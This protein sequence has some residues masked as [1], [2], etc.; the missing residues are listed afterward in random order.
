MKETA[1]GGSIRSR[2]PNYIIFF[3]GACFV[4]LGIALTSKTELGTSPISSIPYN[5]SLAFP[6]LTLGNWTI[7]FNILMVLI[8]LAI[9]RR[10]AN[11]VEMVMQI[12]LALVL[13]YLV[14]VFVFLTAWIIPESYIARLVLMVAGVIVT[15]LGVYLQLVAEVVMLPGDSLSRTVSGVTGKSFG[16]TRMILDITMVIIS[17]VICLISFHDLRGVREGT[18]IAALLTGNTVKVFSKFLGKYF[19]KYSLKR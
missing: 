2:I 4:A 11:P 12:V 7:L 3:I 5:L 17:A 16:D 13:G 9:L 8:Q 14:D 15:A 6:A 18:I 19:E 10:N 1:S